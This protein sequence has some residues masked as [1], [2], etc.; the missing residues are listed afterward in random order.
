MC[1]AALLNSMVTDHVSSYCNH[2]DGGD[3]DGGCPPRASSL[4]E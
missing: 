2:P 1:W 4:C 3:G